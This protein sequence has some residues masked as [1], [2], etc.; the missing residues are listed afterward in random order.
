MVRNM[1]RP[2]TEATTIPLLPV[3]RSFLMVNGHLYFRTPHLSRLSNRY[4][5]IPSIQPHRLFNYTHPSVVHHLLSMLTPSIFRG[6]YWLLLLSLGTSFIAP[7]LTLP[8]QDSPT[9]S[10]LSSRSFL[11][12]SLLPLTL[13]IT[14]G[15]H[16]FQAA[17]WTHPGGDD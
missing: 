7:Y 5:S 3:C 6:F 8:L 1:S 16:V 13:R 4:L 12:F 15:D 10:V 2:S 14:H 11:Q 17:C 9:S